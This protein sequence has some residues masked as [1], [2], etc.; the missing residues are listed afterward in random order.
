MYPSF[1]NQYPR[2]LYSIFPVWC[3]VI[4]DNI[5]TSHYTTDMGEYSDYYI[6]I[7]NVF[8]KQ[9]TQKLKILNQMY[10]EEIKSWK[11]NNNY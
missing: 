5:N 3:N 4:F 11:D 9:H 1:P 10:R 6:N 7:M 8:K 2:T